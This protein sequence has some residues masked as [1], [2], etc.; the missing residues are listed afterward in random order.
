MRTDGHMNAWL[1]YQLRGEPEA[2]AAFLGDE[3]E[4][5]RSGNWQDIEKDMQGN[6]PAQGI[7]PGIRL[8]GI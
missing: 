4:L 5:P 3:A 7:P 6:G 1:L 8:E 2:D